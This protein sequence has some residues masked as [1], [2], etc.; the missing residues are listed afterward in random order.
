[1]TTSAQRAIVF[2][3]VVLTTIAGIQLFALGDQIAVTGRE[4]VD[5]YRALKDPAETLV[6]TPGDGRVPADKALAAMLESTAA[7]RREL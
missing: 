5:A 3:V 4:L 6:W 1:M 2:V 7:L